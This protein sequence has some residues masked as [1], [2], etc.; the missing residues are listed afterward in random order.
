MAGKRPFV[1]EAWAPW[2]IL[3]G[4]FPTPDPPQM[5]PLRPMSHLFLNL[6]AVYT[7]QKVITD[8][9]FAASI[10]IRPETKSKI[11]ILELKVRRKIK[12][13]NEYKL[14][15]ISGGCTLISTSHF[16]IKLFLELLKK[17]IIPV[18]QP[19]C[20]FSLS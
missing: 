5:A 1:V 16:T 3:G 11:C 15:S 13:Q 12:T 20:F 8:N 18:K 6:Y 17:I 2:K 19:L 14:L 4:H 10:Y 9:C 7:K